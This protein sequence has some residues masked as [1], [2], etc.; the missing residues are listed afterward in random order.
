MKRDPVKE[1]LLMKALD[2]REGHEFEEYTEEKQ[3]AYEK[4]HAS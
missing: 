1:K 2:L 4:A 3:K